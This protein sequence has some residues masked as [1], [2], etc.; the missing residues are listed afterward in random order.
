M[1][2]SP[3]FGI[4]NATVFFNEIVLPQYN[5]FL[6]NNSSRRHA[7]LTILVAYHLF[8][9][10]NPCK[11]FT[12]EKFKEYYPDDDALV[13]IFD[14]AREITN[15]TKH[16]KQKTETRRQS[17]FSSEFSKRIRPSISCDTS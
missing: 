12:K 11:T 1:S 14:L 16:F 6:K 2:H 4:N 7:L 3:E 5:D 9:W 15:G 10:A 17:G 8:E 13:E